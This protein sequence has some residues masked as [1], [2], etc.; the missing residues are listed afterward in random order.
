MKQLRGRESLAK[1]L[2]G[3]EHHGATWGGELHLASQHGRGHATKAR[4]GLGTLTVHDFV[5]VGP[6]V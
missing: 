5:R 1:Q 2:R 6:L 4:L 3:Q